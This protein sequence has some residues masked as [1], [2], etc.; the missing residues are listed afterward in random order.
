MFID[1][2]NF[3]DNNIF[4]NTVIPM[5]KDGIIYGRLYNEDVTFFKKNN[6]DSNHYT[7]IIGDNGVGKTNLLNF[8]AN[9][10]HNSTK[11]MAYKKDDLSG[12]K[13]FIKY[14]GSGLTSAE[15]EI[16]DTDIKM[17]NPNKISIPRQ[18]I[19]LYAL[20]FDKIY[21]LEKIL[22]K[23]FVR[24]LSANLCFKSVPTGNKKSKVLIRIGLNNDIATRALLSY[25]CLNHD[26]GNQESY[27]AIKDKITKSETYNHLEKYIASDIV[28]ILERLYDSQIGSYLRNKLNLIQYNPSDNEVGVTAKSFKNAN[29]QRFIYPENNLGELRD[30]LQVE[31]LLIALLEELG[32]IRLNLRCQSYEQDFN[33]NALST[34]EKIM[35]KMF[36][37]FA[38]ITDRR[39]NNIV[40]LYDEPEN[41]LHPQWQKEFPEIFR[42]IAEDIYNIKKSHFIFTTHSPHIIMRS[43]ELPNSFVIR[44]ERDFDDQVKVTPIENVP[45]FS[46][47]HMLLDV[48]GY[49]YYT[50]S[51]KTKNV[52]LT[53]KEK[54]RRSL[55]NKDGLLVATK[56]ENRLEKVNNS[57]R[58]F[59]E[60]DNAYNDL[61]KE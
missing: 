26:Y 30:H 15:N 25:L 16:D 8:V 12:A 38:E 24:Q 13:P 10:Y 5:S 29:S 21:L 60:I 23:Q 34:G 20:H 57:F 48:F 46:I 14:V 4:P 61:F 17:V 9:I 41:S 43:A 45:R 44:M 3:S 52:I 47:E 32:I 39:R 55:S 51:E 22:Q 7:F 37:F 18:L 28:A 40:F 50:E 58:I 6:D 59:E 49:S 31:L 27:Y 54:E 36:S 53:E 42:T 19:L 11:K 1:R 35:I 2:I 33:I 56:F